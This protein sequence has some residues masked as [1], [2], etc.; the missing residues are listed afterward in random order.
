MSTEKRSS[1]SWRSPT[2]E[3]RRIKRVVL[4]SVIDV[5]ADL[6]RE[7]EIETAY[8]QRGAVKEAERHLTE[9]AGNKPPSQ[10]RRGRGF[11]SK[12]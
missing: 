1:G 12:D 5:L 8:W 10:R 11:S 7:W 9:G 4:R 6:D 2:S 3:V